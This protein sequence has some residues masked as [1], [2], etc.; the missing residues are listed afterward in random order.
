MDVSHVC[1]SGEKITVSEVG[2]AISRMKSSKACRRMVVWL[3]C[4]PMVVSKSVSKYH[5]INTCARM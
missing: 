1:R 4:G 3:G 5:K 2:A